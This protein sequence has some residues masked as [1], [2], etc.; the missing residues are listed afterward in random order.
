M[1]FLDTDSVRLYVQIVGERGLPIIFV[2]GWSATCQMWLPLVKRLSKSYRCILYDARGTG[3]SLSTALGTGFEVEDAVADLHAVLRYASAW[4]AHLIGQ[5][6]GAVVGLLAARERPQNFSSL[7][8]IGTECLPPPSDQD[9]AVTA[10]LL[11]TQVRVLL[12]EAATLPYVRQ[13]LLWRYR[14]VPEPHRTKL[15]EDFAATD[16]RAAYGLAQSVRDVVVRA[17]FWEA[18]RQVPIPILLVRG[19][20]DDVLTAATHRAMFDC[21]QRGQTA[22]VRGAGHVPTLEYPEECVELLVNFFRTES[23]PAYRP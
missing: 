15:Y 12:Q 22:T 10:D 14:R 9:Q 21:I 6:I 2:N 5:G 16:P 20:L 4:D 23:L 1:P 3:R 18:L 17:R 8:L 13:L 7:T 11:L 19:A